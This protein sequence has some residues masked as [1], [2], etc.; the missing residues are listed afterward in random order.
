MDKYDPR[1]RTKLIVDE[2]GTWYD[3]LPGT[4]D[5]FLQQQNTVR[6]AVVAGINLNIFNNH[7]DRISMANIAQIV[8]VLQAMILTDGAQM[9]KTPTFYVFKMYNVHQDATLIPTKL[10]T[11]DYT[12]EE[13]AIPALTASASKKDDVV[14][15]T[16]SNAN[17]NEALSVDCNLGD[18]K[19]KVISAQV[20][21]GDKITDY[22]DFGQ[23]EKVSIS[24]LK[25]KDPKKGTLSLE[26]PAHSVVLVQLK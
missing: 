11:E 15:I 5:G 16:L 2:W 23:D 9:V 10:I 19:L 7:A 4:K 25:V 14:S 12:Y 20:V 3:K 6:D 13:D 18:D 21:T 1:G 24:E 22:N 26:I 8:N 17:P